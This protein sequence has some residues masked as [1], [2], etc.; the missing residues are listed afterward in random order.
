MHNLKKYNNCF[1]YFS[2]KIMTDPVIASDYNTYEKKILLNL[3]QKYKKLK[4]PFYSPITNE[5]MNDNYF[6]NLYIRQKI[7]ELKENI[8]NNPFI[9]EFI[10]NNSYLKN[11]IQIDKYVDETINKTLVKK[12]S[13]SEKVKKCSKNKIYQK[14]EKKSKKILNY[15][16]NN[17]KKDTT[18]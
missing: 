15:F 14:S 16:K 11:N 12:S 2:K 17:P 7:F 9:K 3:I 5:L 13:K 8:D 4:M 18:F 1:C 6:P 10:F